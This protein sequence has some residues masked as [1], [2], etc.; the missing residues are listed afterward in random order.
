MNRNHMSVLFGALFAMASL[1]VPAMAW[2]GQGHERIAAAAVLNLPAAAPAFF[3]DGASA[4]AHGSRDPDLFKR[5]LSAE[6]LNSAEGP[7]HY[8]DVEMLKG[9][10]LPGN[11]YAL[12]AWCAAEK[13]D[14]AKLGM[15]PYSVMEWTERLTVAFTEY[16]RWPDDKFIQTKILVYAGI[17]SHYAAD[18]CQ[19]LHTTVDYDGRCNRDG[20]SPHSG[21]HL[22]VDAL[23]E[24]LPANLCAMVSKEIEPFDDLTNGVMAELAASHG[25]VDRI[26]E[27][28][29]A[30]P[31]AKQVL[32][33]GGEL[34]DFARDRFRAASL[35][36]TRLFL[37]AWNDSASTKIPA[38][39]DRAQPGPASP[40]K[41]VPGFATTAPAALSQ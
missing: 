6:A 29:S 38:W 10:K 39:H 3:R 30:L 18:L 5:P 20:K 22:K 23:V 40:R 25:M 14:P 7:E 8:I 26:Y 1:A 27:L 33:A 31:V 9:A 13:V 24:S 37:T 19:P 11:R 41:I 34:A 36:T 17:L 4:I 21:I 35:F 15:L 2:H 28:E 32:P 12:I 16:R